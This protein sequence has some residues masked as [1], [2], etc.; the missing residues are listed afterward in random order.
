MSKV[1]IEV[2]NL[3]AS[4]EHHKRGKSVTL[5]TLVE[6]WRGT[7]AKA[8]TKNLNPYLLLLT[9]Y[10][11]GSDYK[12]DEAEAIVHAMLFE[13]ILCEKKESNGSAFEANYVRRG[14]FAQAVQNGSRKF[15]GIDPLISRDNARK[16]SQNAK[17]H[18][19]IKGDDANPKKKPKHSDGTGQSSP[20]PSHLLV[21]DQTEALYNRIKRLIN[22]CAEEVRT[23]TS[24]FMQCILR[25]TQSLMF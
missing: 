17:K 7:K 9:G 13:K 23:T 10:E 2:L 16:A 18:N 1:A 14:V 22:M 24:M 6:L 12:K 8:Y 4:I 3:L 11:K 21:K 25:L 20:S 19:G 15:L 5:I